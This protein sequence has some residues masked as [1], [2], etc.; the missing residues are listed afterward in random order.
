ML[1]KNYKI[2]K[3]FLAE[4][5]ARYRKGASTMLGLEPLHKMLAWEPAMLSRYFDEKPPVGADAE[6]VQSRLVLTKITYFNPM[7]LDQNSFQ[8]LIQLASKMLAF[9]AA[10]ETMLA[11]L[12][13][14]TYPVFSAWISQA[15]KYVK[16]TKTRTQLVVKDTPDSDVQWCR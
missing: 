6:L 14:Q 1:D 7:S 2:E 3:G 9:P 10:D 11:E 4:V 5:P 8:K 13:T 16:Q 12:T 15:A